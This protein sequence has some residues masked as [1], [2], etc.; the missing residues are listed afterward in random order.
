M[1]IPSEGDDTAVGEGP[2]RRAG[3]AVLRL[4]AFVGV[5]ALFVA[6]LAAGLVTT[7]RPKAVAGTKAPDFELR[8]L[9]RGQTLASRD[10]M[11]AP[12]VVV[13]FWASWCVPCREEAPDLEATWRQYRAQGVRFVGVN[14]QDS[15]DDALAFVKEFGITYPSVRDTNDDLYRDFGVRGV[16]ETFFLDHR[17]RFVSFAQGVELGS[18]GPTKILGAITRPVLRS[19]IDALLTSDRPGG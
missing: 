17:W 10:L 2:P 8:L 14:V 6:L 5:P 4:G 18:R 15:E 3:R 13:N 12:A 11:G 1:T 19:R 7:T 16:P 9:G